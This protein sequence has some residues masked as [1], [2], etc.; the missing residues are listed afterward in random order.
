MLIIPAIDLKD[1]AV[2]RLVQGKFNKKVY[3]RDAVKVARH[4]VRQGA[5]FLHLVDLDGAFSGKPKNFNLVR[6]IVK[7]I[8]VPVELGGGIRSLAAIRSILNSGVARV[9]LGT[10]AVEDAGF[11]KGILLGKRLLVRC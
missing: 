5:K 3:S 1:G 2:V 9:V 11:L 8:S 10:R 7:N 4:W 6:D